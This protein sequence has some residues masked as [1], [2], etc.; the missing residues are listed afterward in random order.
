MCS[1]INFSEKQFAVH[2]L[3]E[4]MYPC[5]IVAGE[6]AFLFLRKRS[7]PAH[8]KWVFLEIHF[9]ISTPIICFQVF[10]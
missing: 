7:H 4:H 1:Q 3:L 10:I 9:A 6:L 2:M 5:N 8:F